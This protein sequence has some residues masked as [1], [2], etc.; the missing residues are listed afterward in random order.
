M[1]AAKLIELEAKATEGPWGITRKHEI[2]PLSKDDDQSFGMVIPIADVFGDNKDYDAELIAYLR[3]HAQDFIRLMEAAE[4][5]M[6]AMNVWVNTYAP[7]LC[8][9]DEVAKA[10][11]I[12]SDGGGTLAYIADINE[13]LHDALAAFK[14]KS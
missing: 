3:N 9:Q 4:K 2:G 14:E 10:R 8:D 7:E 5:G 6:E 13:Q 1:T 12:I 11:Q